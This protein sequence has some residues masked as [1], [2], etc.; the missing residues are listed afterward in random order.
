MDIYDGHI[1]IT[2]S[3]T[4]IPE[5]TL[6]DWR[7]HVEEDGEYKLHEISDKTVFP[8]YKLLR[9]RLMSQ[10]QKLSDSLSDDSQTF[11]LQSLAISRLI[12]HIYRLDEKNLSHI[13]QT[14]SYSQGRAKLFGTFEPAFEDYAEMDLPQLVNELEKT[15]TSW[16]ELEQAVQNGEIAQPPSDSI[17]AQN[18]IPELAS[19]Y[20]SQL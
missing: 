20:P 8:E 2:H 4:A 7:K 19:D 1:G 6:R 3:I 13:S 11:H 17:F 9:H 16:V 10:V 5:R 15:I 18:N 14:N 12:K